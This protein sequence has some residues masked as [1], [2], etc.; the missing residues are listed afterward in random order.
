MTA[1]P[2]GSSIVTSTA[3]QATILKE[4]QLHTS[5]NV[6]ILSDTL[7]FQKELATKLF[8]SIGIGQN[9]DVIV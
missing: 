3:A 1:A 8:Q 5:V 4:A 9:V 2:I 7:D 6:A